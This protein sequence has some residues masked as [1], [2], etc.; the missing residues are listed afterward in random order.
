MNEVQ[1]LPCS[2]EVEKT[3]IRPPQESQEFDDLGRFCRQ[4]AGEE[5]QAVA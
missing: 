5:L 3:V 2:F 4:A 1:A